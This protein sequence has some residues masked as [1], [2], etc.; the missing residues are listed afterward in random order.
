MSS[1]AGSDEDSPPSAAVRSS[2]H[3]NQA[4]AAQQPSR[5]KGTA[6][7]QKG[8]TKKANRMLLIGSDLQNIGQP[9]NVGHLKG[10]AEIKA[11]TS[12][13]DITK[14]LKE[15]SVI[16][17][18]TILVHGHPGG[19]LFKTKQGNFKEMTLAQA[20]KWYQ[21]HVDVNRPRASVIHL[22]S[23]NI[24]L[25]PTPLIEF[26]KIFR[27]SSIK[28]WNH[29]YV[30]QSKT[31]SIPPD[32]NENDIYKKFDAWP[33]LASDVKLE[34]LVRR[35]GRHQVL[36][37]W[38]RVDPSAASLPPGPKSPD[39]TNATR[40]SFKSA[41]TAQSR[42]VRNT[43]ELEKLIAELS[44]WG[45]IEPEKPLFQIEVEMSEFTDKIPASPDGGIPD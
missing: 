32:V 9:Y 12:W 26:A 17:E 33:Y 43:E 28:A 29:F 14:I 6:A 27:A 19:F 31:L 22:Q 11:V 44:E 40:K 41:K 7:K 16:S 8:G 38:Y 45:F 23:C 20:T 13:D 25:D 30:T 3:P 4:S 5:S 36:V 34:E 24:G 21:S 37:E 18:L 35:P 2:S 42:V 39:D 1:D 10:E 15:Y